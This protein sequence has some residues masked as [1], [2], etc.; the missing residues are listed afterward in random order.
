MKQLK[1]VKNMYIVMDVC[2]IIVGLLILFSPIKAINVLCRIFGAV[3]VLLGAVKILGYFTKD[4]FQLAFQF[5]FALGII[6]VILGAVL[7]FRTSY[8][9]E[10]L[11]VCVGIV[12]LIDG[13]LKLQTAVDA[14]KFGIEKWWLIL[15]I[16]L[17]VS[18][19]GII[20][21][22]T[23]FA[24]QTVAAWVIGI[25]LVLDGVLNICVVLSTVK[26]LRRKRLE[27]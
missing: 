18:I 9:V 26:T 8:M 3:L 4:I 27:V 11:S 25:N 7:I 20:L 6:S 12:I 5:D 22:V 19:V 10:I 17:L 1:I 13:A 23:P 14:R 16:A 15:I 24:A 2:L 21:M